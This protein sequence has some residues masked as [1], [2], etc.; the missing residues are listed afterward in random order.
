MKKF[1][2]QITWLNGEEET[3]EIQTQ[4]IEWSID[5]YSRNRKPFSWKIVKVEDL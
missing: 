2:V 4:D 1:T 5:Q 3:I